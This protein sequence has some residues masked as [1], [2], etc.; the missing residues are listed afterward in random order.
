VLSILHLNL[1]FIGSFA[2]QTSC[3]LKK[4]ESIEWLNLYSPRLHISTP[5]QNRT[6][7]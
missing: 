4:L 5:G 1:Q 7:S 3:L 6:R 2:E